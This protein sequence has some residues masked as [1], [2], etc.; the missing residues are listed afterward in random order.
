MVVEWTATGKN[1]PY[2]S[3]VRSRITTSLVT[4]EAQGAG[5]VET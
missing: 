5:E 4:Y 1:P 3:S 2:R